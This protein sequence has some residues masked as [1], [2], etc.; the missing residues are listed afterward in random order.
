MSKKRDK[1]SPSSDV[2][3]VTGHGSLAKIATALLDSVDQLIYIVDSDLRIILINETLKRWGRELNISH[4]NLIGKTITEAFPFLE[5]RIIDEYRRILKTRETITKEEETTDLG[6]RFLY[7]ESRKIPVVENGKVTYI[8]SIVSDVGERKRARESLKASEEKYRRMVEE[9]NEAVYRMSLPDGKY[10]YFSR[11]AREVFG[12]SADDFIEKNKFIEEIIHPEF[13]EYFEQ[14]WQDLLH[15]KVHPIY[16]YKIVD[17]EGNER[18]IRQTNRGI[19]DDN[20]QIIAIE[21]ICRDETDRINNMQMLEERIRFETMLADLSAKFV[22]IPISEIDKEIEQGLQSIITFFGVERAIIY[23]I[24]D[25]DNL[26]NATHSWTEPGLKPFPQSFDRR[27]FSWLVNQILEKEVIIVNSV[28]DLPETAV[29]EKEYYK[30]AGLKSQLGIPLVIGGEIRGAMSIGSHREEKQWSK[31]LIQRLRLVGEVFANA[32][33][34]LKGEGALREA[35]NQIGHYQAIVDR[36]PA[37]AIRWKASEESLV[38]FVS[39]NIRQFGYEP[40]DFMSGRIRWANVVHPEDKPRIRA[41]VNQ[42][43]Q[44][45]S[46]EFTQHYRLLTKSGEYRW[47]EDRSINVF[48]QS[49]KIMHLEGVLLDVTEAKLARDGLRTSEEKYRVLVENVSASIAVFDYQGEFLFA[50]RIAAG[51]LGLTAEEII[52]K[53]QWDVFPK[54]IADRQMENVRKVIDEN[55][56]FV[57]ETMTVVD[58]QKKWYVVNLQP[59]ADGDGNIAAALVIAHDVTAQRKSDEALRH[60]EETFRLAMESTKDAVWD[61]DIVTNQVY[62]N[63]GHFSMLGYEPDEWT[64]DQREWRERIHP[65]DHDSV[66]QTLNETLEGKRERYE[67]EYRLRTK[68]GD[69][70]WVLGRGK[71]VSFAADGK[72]L[73]MIGTNTDITERKQAEEAL[74]HSEERFRRQFEA[75]PIPAYTWEHREGN[76]FLEGC[77]KAA[78]AITKG[79][80]KDY[81][82]SKANEMYAHMP[83]LVSDMK[84]CHREKTSITREMK[85]KFMSTGENK[86]LIVHYVYAP[87]DLVVVHTEDI[88]E[89][90]Q[91]ESGLQ[92]AHDELEKRVRERTEELAEANEALQVEREA[93]RQKNIV[94]QEVLDQI[95]EGKRQMASQIQTNINRVALPILKTLENKV[96]PAGIPFIELL[97]SSIEDIASPLISTL[98]SKFT[99]LTPREI[100][101][102]NMVRN[103]LSCKE[104]AQA[105]DTSEQTVLKQRTIIRKKLGITNSKINLASYLKS[106]E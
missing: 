5:D 77:N 99:L 35:L 72:P 100:E 50:N 7:T 103:G 68:S 44:N 86:H 57:E 26:I 82:G 63:P 88:T 51:A 10:E 70:I 84:R 85:Y 17:P 29:G 25:D 67:V 27:R 80:I 20:G 48:D 22:N 28:N 71:I 62:R 43:L 64:P 58:N 66:F 8:V 40:E 104:I 6:G 45:G 91:A 24:E 56:E 95:E 15:G 94:L 79:N 14:A 90:K 37:V 52:G 55:M 97:K 19:F 59:Y 93:L 98:E 32:L 106:L 60:S 75:L 39:D 21:G 69:Y 36:S 61:W 1:S 74:R 105:L 65:D 54:E 18:W 73:R 16:D 13:K 4:D 81:L 46:V 96:R 38:E 49:G 53:T 11:A 87:P 41:E 33:M 3:A 101:I 42:Y 12:H 34:R 2:K 89:L 83:D 92:K 47:I 78:Y 30:A 23:Q 31:E 76:F 102:C 9:L